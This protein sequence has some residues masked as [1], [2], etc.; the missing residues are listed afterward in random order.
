MSRYVIMSGAQRVAIADVPTGWPDYVPPA[1][2]TKQIA[3]AADEAWAAA[4]LPGYEP[5]GSGQPGE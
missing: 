1:G 4:N 3:D 2:M 5:P